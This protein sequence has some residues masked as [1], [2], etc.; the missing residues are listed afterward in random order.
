MFL[1]CNLLRLPGILPFVLSNPSILYSII[2]YIFI[3]IYTV[4]QICMYLW[5]LMKLWRVISLDFFCDVI[6]C[7]CMCV[8]TGDRRRLL[9]Q[10]GSNLMSCCTSKFNIVIGLWCLVCFETLW[11]LVG[12]FSDSI[13][14]TRA[15]LSVWAWDLDARWLWRL[16]AT[17]TTSTK[18][19]NGSSA[20]DA[21]DA[22]EGMFWVLPGTR[23]F[24]TDVHN[25][26]W[27]C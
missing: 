27:Y 22:E 26:C 23:I 4:H 10:L 20:S 17:V 2:F 19:G 16:W 18:D 7:L 5:N 21:T 3:Y 15:T 13:G 25:A 24:D 8:L 14:G 9:Q 1:C 11:T 6:F 12:N